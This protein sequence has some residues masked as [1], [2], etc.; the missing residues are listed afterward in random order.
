MKKAGYVLG[1]AAALW[2]LFLLWVRVMTF[3][4]VGPAMRPYYDAVSPLFGA[5][6]IWL[7]LSAALACNMI[8][9]LFRGKCRG[10]EKAVALVLALLCLISVFGWAII[11]ALVAAA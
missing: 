7:I 5:P 6:A 1:L 8:V 10:A 11:T 9:R 2:M 3:A 4:D